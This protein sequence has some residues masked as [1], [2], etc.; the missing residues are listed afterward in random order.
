MGG[1]DVDL[2]PTDYKVLY[3]HHEMCQKTL[4]TLENTGEPFRPVI[5]VSEHEKIM[6]F[7][8]FDMTP[9]G[10]EEAL[11]LIAQDF[12]TPE[13]VILTGFAEIY[14]ISEEGV[15]GPIYCLCSHMVNESG[16]GFVWCTTVEDD[17]WIPVYPGHLED[18]ET[19]FDLL[20]EYVVDDDI[21]DWEDEDD[22]D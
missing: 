7:V 10:V 14:E 22:E 17:E 5:V 8:G 18:S 16:I 9:S 20:A 2:S 21:Y 11:E 4:E 15:N 6:P 3:A 13:R 19:Y 12:P 1:V